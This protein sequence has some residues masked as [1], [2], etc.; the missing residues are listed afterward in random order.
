MPGVRYLLL[1]I[2]CLAVFT[3]GT[4]ASIIDGGTSFYG[5]T[6]SPETFYNVSNSLDAIADIQCNVYTYTEGDYAGK[7][8]YTYQITNAS[9]VDLKFLTMQIFCPPDNIND[10]AKTGVDVLSL[11]YL[12]TSS[13]ALNIKLRIA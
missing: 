12:T 9:E 13:R 5:T 4:N 2:A 11:G 8:A 7:Y 10:Y 6:P 1:F 3:A